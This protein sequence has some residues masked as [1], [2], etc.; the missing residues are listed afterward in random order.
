MASTVSNESV[1]FDGVFGFELP[2]GG[3]REDVEA[4]YPDIVGSINSVLGRQWPMDCWVMVS[5]R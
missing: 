4:V 2:H 1:Y 3:S 5:T